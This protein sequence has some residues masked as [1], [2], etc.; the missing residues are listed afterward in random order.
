MARPPR[1]DLLLALALAAAS[2][3][4]VL[5]IDPIA[6][7]PVGALIALGGTLPVAWRR[8]HPTA[9][10]LVGSAIWLVPADGFLYLG[11]LLGFI[12]YYSLALYEPSDRKVLAV[13]A[14]G[15]A[16][17][18]AGSVL[19]GDV[20]GEYFGVLPGVVLPTVA[21]RVVRR[22]RDLTVRLELER[23]RAESAAVVEERGRI[24]RELHDVVAHGISV[25]AIQADAAEAALDRDPALAREPLATIRRSAKTSLE[26]MRHLL[27]VLREDGDGGELAPQPGLAQ[28]DE[29][30]ERARG[31]GVDV[32]LDVSGEPR[33]LAPGLDLSAYRIVQEALTNVRKHADGAPATVRVAWEPRALALEIRDRGPGGAGTNGNGHG[34]VGMRERVRVHGGELHAGPSAGGGFAVK[35][36]LPL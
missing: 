5:V 15:V 26:E 29:L 30:V 11:Y 23:E 21:G 10:A 12:L 9:A 20:L 31:A 1:N 19:R 34:L 16:L 2:L 6:A 4:Q 24:A 22:L 17:G 36:R 25:I 3:L 13:A 8:L 14:V 27:G 35:A 7:R 33:E 28:L 18:I 32:T